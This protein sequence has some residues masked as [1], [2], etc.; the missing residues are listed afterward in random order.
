M[1]L[2][3]K[4]LS[5]KYLKFMLTH[6]MGTLSEWS[7]ANKLSLNMTKTVLMYF[8]QKDENFTNSLDETTIPR[9]RMT[10]FLGM[11]IDYSLNWESQVSHVLNKMCTNRH[12]LSL[13]RNLLPIS[14]LRT[15]YFSH[16][17]SHMQH[18][19][20]VWGSMISKAQLNKIYNLQKQCVRLLSK[21]KFTPIDQLFKKHRVIKFPDMIKMELCKFGFKL[22]KKTIPEPLHKLMESRGDKK[23]ISTTPEASIFLTFTD[24][25]APSTTTV[26]Y[27]EVLSNTQNY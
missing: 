1:T 6:D 3:N 24:I 23:P 19:L 12:L 9:V 17:Y 22:A 5:A 26:C 21:D 13:S 15:V 18:S 10:K 8:G 27:A 2:F 20:G 7:K 16:I 11:M 14:C 25:V 4:H